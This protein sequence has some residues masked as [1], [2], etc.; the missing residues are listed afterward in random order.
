[1]EAWMYGAAKG[2]LQTARDAL[3][4]R[5]RRVLELT[6]LGHGQRGAVEHGFACVRH[7]TIPGLSILV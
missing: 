5:G 7:P 2:D 4:A 1:M 6:D 3:Q